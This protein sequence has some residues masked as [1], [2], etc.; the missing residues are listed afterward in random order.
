MSCFIKS[1]HCQKNPFGVMKNINKGLLYLFPMVDLN[2]RQCNLVRDCITLI[3]FIL[4]EPVKKYPAFIPLSVFYKHSGFLRQ[5]VALSLERR[6]S[7]GKGQ[8]T[9]QIPFP[10]HNVHLVLKIAMMR[11]QTVVELCHGGFF[12]IHSEQVMGVLHVQ[13]DPSQRTVSL[14]SHPLLPIV[15][16]G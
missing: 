3:N 7:M 2:L 5:Y 12:Y 4:K 8:S 9:I 6:L 10:H 14:L 1:I 15:P 16:S 11:A 13:R